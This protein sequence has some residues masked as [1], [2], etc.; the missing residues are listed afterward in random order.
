MRL[1][2]DSARVEILKYE[3]ENRGRD[4]MKPN[5]GRF[6]LY[7]SVLHGNWVTAE[8][9]EPGTEEHMNSKRKAK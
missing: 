5:V 2:D 3:Q 8:M 1:I 9:M 6:A 4:A 7:H